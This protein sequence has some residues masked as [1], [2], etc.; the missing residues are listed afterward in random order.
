[1]FKVK[2]FTIILII[3][4]LSFYSEA[5]S[6]NE[7]TITI[8]AFAKVH[9]D[10]NLGIGFGR[11]LVVKVENISEPKITNIE[12]VYHSGRFVCPGNSAPFVGRLEKVF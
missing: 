4:I 5:F 1:M 3:I 7:K 6:Q 8:K 11:E 12:K 2:D 10:H 9:Q